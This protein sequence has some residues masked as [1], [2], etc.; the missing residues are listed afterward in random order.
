MRIEPTTAEAVGFAVGEDR[1]GKI[2]IVG[3]LQ[4]PKTDANGWVFAIPGP[5]GAP[6]WEVVR[7]GP[8]Q[9]PDET[10]GLAVDA[11]GY[12]DIVGSEFDALQPRAFA[13]RLYP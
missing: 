3:A 2:I 5:M 10:A 8:G 4:Q 9:G 11:W 6:V 12:S 1:E 13:L 7:N